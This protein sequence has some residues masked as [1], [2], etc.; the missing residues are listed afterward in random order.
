ML[1]APLAAIGD[2]TA[3]QG[4]C[5]EV[6]AVRRIS[7]ALLLLARACRGRRRCS[8][9]VAAHCSQLELV[10]AARVPEERRPRSVLAGNHHHAARWPLEVQLAELCCLM[11]MQ[12]HTKKAAARSMGIATLAYLLG[13]SQVG[14]TARPRNS[15]RCFTRSPLHRSPSEASPPRGLCGE[16]LVVRE[17]PPPSRRSLDLARKTTVLDGCCAHRSRLELVVA[18]R[19]PEERR[20]CSVLGA[21]CSPETTIMLLAGA[22]GATRRVVLLDEDAATHQKA[23]LARWVSPRSPTCLVAHKLDQV[24]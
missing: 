12:L 8:M 3:R 10:V 1:T 22:G 24:G 13:C 11:K 9:D 2:F 23:M 19:V 15:T 7:T 14:S 4:L 17:S 21:R 18:A 16:V 5:G 20:S 6:Q